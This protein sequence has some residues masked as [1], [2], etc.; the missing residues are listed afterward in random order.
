MIVAAVVVFLG[1]VTAAI[2]A[3]LVGIPALPPELSTVLG[4]VLP[5]LRGGY[6]VLN[7]F[8]YA[9]VIV[10][11]WTFTLVLY[12]IE[13]AYKLVMWVLKKIPMFSVSD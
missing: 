2:M 3:T 11:L 1:I 7:T 13:K 9:G 12:N 10:P 8:C 5:I 6:G 4:Y